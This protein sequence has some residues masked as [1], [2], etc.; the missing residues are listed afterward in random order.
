LKHILFYN[1]KCNRAI[2]INPLVTSHLTSGWITYKKEET[3]IFDLRLHDIKN[4]V[5]SYYYMFARRWDM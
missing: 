4:S 1:K 3:I 5:K 2:N